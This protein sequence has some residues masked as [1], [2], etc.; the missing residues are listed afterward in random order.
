MAKN[1]TIKEKILAFLTAR[2]IKKVEFF[3]RTGIQSSNFKGANLASAPGSDMLVKILT[4]YPELSAEWLL[5]GNGEM[6]KSKRISEAIS[7]SNDAI[8]E[9]KVTKNKELSQDISIETRPRIPFDAAAGTLSIAVDSVSAADCE[10]IPVI[11]TFPRY[12]FSI[13]A[14][15]DS[16]APDFQSGDELA[17]AFVKESSFIQWG[18]PHVIDTAQGV[19]LK[20]IFNSKNNILCRSINQEYPDFEIPKTEIF[21]IAIVVVLIRHF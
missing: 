21:H 2:G 18:R 10:Q 13:I 12:D 9:Y 20:K 11:P 8:S 6:L 3:E 5:T 19:V 17:C 4:Y 7:L 15:G 14:R 1:L 16:M